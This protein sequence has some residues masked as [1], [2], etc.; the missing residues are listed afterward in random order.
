[1]KCLIDSNV[2]IRAHGPLGPYGYQAVNKLTELANDGTGVLSV[3]SLAEFVHYGVTEQKLNP[4]VVAYQVSRLA[5]VFPVLP[6]SYAVVE[7]AIWGMLSLG[8]DYYDAQAWA[9]ART[10]G[11]RRL[12]TEGRWHKLVVDKIEYHDLVRQAHRTTWDDEY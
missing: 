11:V 6:V 5:E 1:M 12:L 9:V 3:Q 10:N 2:L 4:Y 8:L 7:K